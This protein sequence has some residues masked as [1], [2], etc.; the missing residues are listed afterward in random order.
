MNRNERQR[1]GRSPR[2]VTA[3]GE[4]TG[5]TYSPSCLFRIS[6]EGFADC[7]SGLVDGC[8]FA[9]VGLTGE[10]YRSLGQTPGF[11]KAAVIGR[12]GRLLLR[13]PVFGSGLL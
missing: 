12:Y 7:A 5:S 6:K 13:D 10:F 4:A 3:T 9:L 1:E 2:Y 11:A 8:P